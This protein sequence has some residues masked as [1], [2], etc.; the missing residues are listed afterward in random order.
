MQ[1]SATTAPAS[2]GAQLQANEAEAVTEGDS[3]LERP[4][5]I[6]ASPPAAHA[7]DLDPSSAVLPSR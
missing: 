1:A 7:R 4:M 6:E 3:L 5:P 2:L